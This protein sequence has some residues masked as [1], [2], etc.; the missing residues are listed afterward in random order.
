MNGAPLPSSTAIPHDWSCPAS[1]VTSRPPS[2]WWISKSRDSIAHRHIGH[3][4]GGPSAARSKRHP[5]SMF[6]RPSRHWPPAR[7]PSPGWH[8]PSAAASR[9]SKYKSTTAPGIAPIWPPS[10]PPIPGVNGPTVGPLF[11]ATQT[12]RVRATDTSGATQTDQRR[13]PMPDGSTGRHSRTV[14]FGESTAEI[15]ETNPRRCATRTP[16]IRRHEPGSMRRP[17]IDDRELDERP[18]PASTVVRTGPG[19]TSRQALRSAVAAPPGV[20]RPACCEGSPH[21]S[22]HGEMVRGQ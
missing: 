12:L 7:L 16:L 11:P 20:V 13:P 2:G 18:R 15:S 10:T 5:A 4:A 1:T 6:P 22:W 19:E 8:G 21:G 17:V 14:V 3:D 9:A